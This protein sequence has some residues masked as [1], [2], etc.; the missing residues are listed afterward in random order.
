MTEAWG[1]YVHLPWCVRKCPYCDFNSHALKGPLPETAYVEALLH[2]LRQ[3]LALLEQQPAIAS[4]FLGGGTPSLFSAGAIASLLE[5]IARQL[6]LTADC[7]ITLEAN[8]GTVEKARFS[9]YY[10]AGVNRLSLG[11]Q[12]FADEKLRALGRIHSGTEA[13]RALDAAFAAGFSRVNGDLMFGLPEQHI[14]Q[15][16]ADVQTLLQWPVEHIS[17]YQLTLEPNTLFA[18]RP[19]P[20]PEHD[21]LADMHE[22]LL[23]FLRE[24][25]FCRYEISALARPGCR[26]RHNLNYWRFG[27]YLG[28]GAG[29]HGKWRTA[30]GD[31]LRSLRPRHPQAYQAAIHQQQA[32]TL[33]PIAEADL[34]FE[35]MLNALRLVEGVPET[36]FE[37]ATG[38]PLHALEPTLSRLR[39]AGWLHPQRLACTER[40]LSFLDDTVAAF[41]PSQPS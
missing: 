5:G 6:P 15:A 36:R 25:G 26:S 39:Q 34:P 22:T 21:T 27:H 40:G 41:L 13:R 18:H 29:A 17:L 16:L 8:P 12:S 4:I 37:Q 33:S 31:N 7:E 30:T 24:Q 2:D 11:L 23:A 10:H 28:I 14:D 32:P 1:L 19:P 35:F 3:Q 38:L 20:L 9:G